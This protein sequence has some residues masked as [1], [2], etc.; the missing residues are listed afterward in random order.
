MI[1]RIIAP[2]F[3]IGAVVLARGVAGGRRVTAPKYHLP[4]ASHLESPSGGGGNPARKGAASCPS[5]MS[6]LGFLWSAAALLAVLGPTAW[7]SASRARDCDK[8][9]LVPMHSTATQR[10]G[11]GTR[12]NVD[13]PGAIQLPVNHALGGTFADSQIKVSFTKCKFMKFFPSTVSPTGLFSRFLQNFA[14][15][16]SRAGSGTGTGHRHARG[17]PTFAHKSASHFFGEPFTVKEFF[18]VYL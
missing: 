8:H 4:K 10:I 5:P 15:I 9:P 3:R 6:S 11:L 17:R 12:A 7:L 2:R 16:W 18:F 13:L 14:S 1:I